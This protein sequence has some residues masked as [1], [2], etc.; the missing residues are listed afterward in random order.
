VESWRRSLGTGLDPIELLAP[1]EADQSEIRE[2]WVE[3][4]LGS[5]AH[6]LAE[7]LRAI[8]EDSESLIVVSGASG[9]LLHIEGADRLKERAG[10][11]N[12]IEGARYSEAAAGTNGIG[13]ALAADPALQ[14]F[15]FEHFN[16]RHHGWTCSASPVHDP[17]TGRLVG[18][19]DLSSRW[20][21]VNRLSLALTTTAAR[22]VEQS[23]L[24]ARRDQDARLRRRYGDLTTRSTDLSSAVTAT[25]SLATGRRP[26]PSRSPCPR[27]VARSFWATVRSPPRS[28]SA[29]ARPT[30]S[31]GSAHAASVPHQPRRSSARNS[32]LASSPG[33]K[34]PCGRRAIMD[35]P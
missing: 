34:P 11:M 21:T 24:D 6:V 16:Q 29:G 25:R 13:T 5:V 28:R 1:V 4:P 3:H 31:A 7:Q 2:R 30:L 26:T 8:A 32:M 15:A 35:P 27:V 33:N 23:L 10:E 20:K 18:A 12:F 9:L 14:L 22:A 19:I 17:V